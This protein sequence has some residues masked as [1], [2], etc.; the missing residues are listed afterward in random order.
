MKV[1]SSAGK[2]E[3]SLDVKTVIGFQGC[4]E[5][6]KII[7]TVIGIESGYIGSNKS[8]A[9]ELAEVKKMIKT[10]DFFNKLVDSMAPTVFAHQYIKRAILLMLLGGVHKFTH[11]GINIRGGGGGALMF[12]LFEIQIVLNLS[13]S[14]LKALRVLNLGFND[15]A[16]AVLV[17]ISAIGDKANDLILDMYKSVVSTFES[18]KC[19]QV[20]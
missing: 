8:K 7:S 3:F 6:V 10:P 9:E 1:I 11:E 20:W 18:W 14:R 15:I 19:N 17:A 16:D 12:V 2:H 13:F 4:E 5:D